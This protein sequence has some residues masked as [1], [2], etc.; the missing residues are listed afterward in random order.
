MMKSRSIIAVTLALAS[1]AAQA[2]A[3]G[4]D[5]DGM[6]FLDQP[7]RA[8]R[9]EVRAE[10]AAAQA[11]GETLLGDGGIAFDTQPSTRT[12]AEVKA[13]LAEA[14]R[15]GLTD[16]SDTSVPIATPEQEEQIRRA[17]QMAVAASHSDRG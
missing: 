5:G 12:R 8:T 4:G 17:G 7:S 10:L 14:R 11:H 15:L 16:Y 13:E 3:G 2:Q 1:F 9:A 6:W